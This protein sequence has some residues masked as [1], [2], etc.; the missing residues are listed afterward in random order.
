MADLLIL[1]CGYLGRRVGR[2]CRSRGIRAY[3][4]TRSAEKAE[5]IARWGI[6]PIVCDL[7]DPDAPAKWPAVD[8]VLFCMGHGKEGRPDH[9][10][11]LENSLRAAR[12]ARWVYA[13]STGVYGQQ[14]G[15]WIDEDSPAE[16]KTASGRACLE[17]EAAVRNSGR[18][19]AIVRFAGLYGPGRV[20][21]RASLERGEPIPGDPTHH[22]N[23]IHIDDAAGAVV[24]AFDRPD[25]DLAIAADDMPVTRLEYYEGAA[26]LLGAAPPR[27]SGAGERDASNK[28]ASN[29]RLRQEWGVPLAYPTIRT[30]LPHALATPDQP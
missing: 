8:R 2:L 10:I 14:G 20:I 15:E 29:R 23:L 17:A 19:A 22:L 11:G 6:E 30:G 16:P 25:G 7:L 21:R 9:R 27:F 4:T 12:E 3:G 24:A 18:P 1:G 26:E 28:R 13:S 5:Q